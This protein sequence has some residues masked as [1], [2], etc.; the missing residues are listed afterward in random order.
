MWY[1]HQS[2]SLRTQPPLIAPGPLGD[3]RRLYSHA[4][5]FTLLTCGSWGTLLFLLHFDV[6]RELSLHTRTKWN[7][8]VQLSWLLWTKLIEH[9]QIQR[10]HSSASG[11]IGRALQP[12][13]T[14][15]GSNAISTQ[16]K[17]FFAKWSGVNT[18][19]NF[20]NRK[21]FTGLEIKDTVGILRLDT[22]I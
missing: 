6:I 20:L 14:S 15:D 10:S 5:K 3:E 17:G 18:G 16:T 8:F 2:R 22:L 11:I 9:R 4:I 12:W 21:E 7:L 19:S 1:E 13:N